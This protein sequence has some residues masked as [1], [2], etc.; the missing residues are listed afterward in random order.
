MVIKYRYGIDV[1]EATKEE[2]VEFVQTMIYIHKTDATVRD[3]DMNM[4]NIYKNDDPRKLRKLR[5]ANI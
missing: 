3:N 1:D 5:K 4:I 2:L